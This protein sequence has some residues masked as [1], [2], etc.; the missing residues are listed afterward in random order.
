LWERVCLGP[1][2]LL[3]AFPREIV[4]IK[5]EVA[6]SSSRVQEQQ[7]RTMRHISLISPGDENVATDEQC[8]LLRD[9]RH[10]IN[11]SMATIWLFNDVASN[12]E[13]K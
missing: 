11:I 7:H 6:G 5:A 12:V 10:T 9:L 2:E 3:M 4:L 8:I 13:F 1:Y